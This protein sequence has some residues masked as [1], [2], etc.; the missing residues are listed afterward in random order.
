MSNSQLGYSLIAK[1]YAESLFASAS[2]KKEKDQLLSDLADFE[3][4]MS[5]STDLKEMMSSPVFNPSDKLKA[6]QAICKKAKLSQ[7]FTNF[8]SVMAQNGRLPLVSVVII[9]AKRLLAE[10]SG[11]HE[12]EITTNYE[13]TAKELQALQKTLS[14][15]TGKDIVLDNKVD[16]QI[17]GGMKLRIGS[18][19]VDDTVQTRLERLERS[20]SDK[21]LLDTSL[22]QN[23]KEV[24]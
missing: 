23:L 10:L 18:V 17:L 14:K 22:T 11:Q 8:L 9:E 3:N 12:A 21:Q 20:L 5:S 6:I 1:R 24:G 7:L 2:T 15:Q 19:M 16:E 4:M 13:L